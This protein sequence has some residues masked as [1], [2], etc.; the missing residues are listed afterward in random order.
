MSREIDSAENA[1]VRFFSVLFRFCYYVIFIPYLLNRS[2]W[3]T[4]GWAG[5]TPR[6][7]RCNIIRMRLENKPY[8][9]KRRPGDTSRAR[10]F[11]G[12]RERYR[13]CSEFA[14][15]R[16]SKFRTRR[17]NAIKQYRTHVKR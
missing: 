8:R 4:D 2:R 1:N 7:R 6:A 13:W 11:I 15:A 9:Q 16:E 12:I 14:A 10:V 3:R 17:V 5:G